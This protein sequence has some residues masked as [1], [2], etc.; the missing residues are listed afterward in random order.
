M[1][2]I[3]IPIKHNSQRVPNK[4]FRLFEGKPLWERTIDKFA[5]TK[6][7]V[8]IDTDSEDVI[9]KCSSRNVVAFKRNKNLIGDQVS[10]VELLKD[11]RK[12][13]KIKS[14]ICQIHVT[15]PFLQI[16]HIDAAF[17]K[18]LLEDYDSVFSANIIQSRFWRK[19]KYGLCPVNHNPM[20]LEQTQ[21]LPKLYEE[22]SYLYAFKP[23]VLD[24]NNRIGY[25]PYILEINYPYNLDIDTEEDW[26]LV[27]SII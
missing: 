19:E 4:N 2:T 8:Y 5:N 14:P 16:N 7:K 22:N 25:N 1:T 15:S 9:K 27:N 13:F 23:E 21:D 10:V 6:Y 20:K 26:K 11:F 17:N 3:F 24:L 12:S 18:I